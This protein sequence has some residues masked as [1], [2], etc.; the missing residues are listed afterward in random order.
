MSIFHL[1]HVSFSLL[2]KFNRHLDP[3]KHIR[4]C[5]YSPCLLLDMHTEHMNL[6][7]YLRSFTHK[8]K[9]RPHKYT[10]THHHTFGQLMVIAKVYVSCN[11][12]KNDLF[13][14]KSYIEHEKQQCSIYFCSTKNHIKRGESWERKK[15]D[16][17][18]TAEHMCANFFF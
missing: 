2:T 6:R 14:T 9:T 4:N 3:S 11:S 18:H 8:Y 10:H 12:D 1:A 15:H 16:S 7:K 17:T 5:L 13:R